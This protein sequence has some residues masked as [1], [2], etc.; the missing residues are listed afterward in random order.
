MMEME[1]VIREKER[2]FKHEDKLLDARLK[3][4]MQRKG[5]EKNLKKHANIGTRG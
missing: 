3:K 2:D 1:M 5:V 4:R